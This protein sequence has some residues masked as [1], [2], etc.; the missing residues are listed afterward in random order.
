[1]NDKVAVF[2]VVNEGMDGRDKTRV[3]YSSTRESDR[4]AFFSSLGKNACYYR[5][6]DRVMSLSSM[7]QDFMRKLDGNDKL[8]LYH[9]LSFDALQ[10][11]LTTSI[12]GNDYTLW[13]KGANNK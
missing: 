3:T 2:Q 1:M 9:C 13:S 10:D 5:M 11:G 12:G 7:G 6:V 4:D 8:V